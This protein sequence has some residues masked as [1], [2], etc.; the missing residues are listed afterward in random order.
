MPTSARSSPESLAADNGMD[1]LPRPLPPPEY[2]PVPSTGSIPPFAVPTTLTRVI[3]DERAI[4]K[5]LETMIRRSG[6]T[7]RQVADAMGVLPNS[8]QQVLSG[9][10]RKPSLLWFLKV[11]E[12]CGA[13]LTLTI[14]KRFA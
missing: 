10:R 3:C 9:R 1:E 14:P 8:I 13:S 4:A 7:T 12:I 5:L 11:A 6:M 2:V